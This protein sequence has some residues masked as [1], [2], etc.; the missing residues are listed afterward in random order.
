[1]YCVA[2]AMM[3]TTC[4]IANGPG[5]RWPAFRGTGNSVSAATDLP[6]NWSKSDGITWSTAIGDYG[7]SSPVVW[8]DRVFVTSA[9]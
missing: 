7:Q 4:L 6:L 5:D 2:T 1:M 3:L 9:V 8:N